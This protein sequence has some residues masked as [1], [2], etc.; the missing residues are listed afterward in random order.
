MK[1]DIAETPIFK[2]LTINGILEFDPAQATSTLRSKYIFIK[3]GEL[4]AGTSDS[5]FPN[6][7]II[8]LL[9]DK[10]NLSREIN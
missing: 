4:N 6:K 8:K 1:I 2:S 3:E 5:P 9:G 7:I 10:T